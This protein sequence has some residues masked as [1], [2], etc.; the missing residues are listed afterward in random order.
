MVEFVDNEE[1]ME[2]LVD[3]EKIVD[4]VITEENPRA[5]GSRG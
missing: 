5:E 3:R 1:T 2:E 4:T